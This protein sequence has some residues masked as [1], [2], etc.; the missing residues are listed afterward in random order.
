MTIALVWPWA[1]LFVVGLVVEGWALNHSDRTWTLSRTVSY[2]GKVWPISILLFGIL[3]GHFF[4]PWAANPLG[5]GG[6]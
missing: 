3:M 6:G 2:I 5:V 4:W 1:I